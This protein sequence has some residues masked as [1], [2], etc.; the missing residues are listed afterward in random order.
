MAVGNRKIFAYIGAD[1]EAFILLIHWV[2]VHLVLSRSW[3][4]LLVDY[5]LGLCAEC[6]PG[7]FPELFRFIQRIYKVEVAQKSVS[8][9]GRAELA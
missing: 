5:N 4:V 1:P 8:V 9:G 2:H 6:E 3:E 7:L